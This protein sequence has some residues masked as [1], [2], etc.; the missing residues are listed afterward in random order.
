MFDISIFTQSLVESPFSSNYSLKSLQ[1][2]VV[3]CI[4]LSCFGNCFCL[5]IILIICLILF[6]VSIVIMSII[7]H[8]VFPSHV[9]VFLCYLSPNMPES[10]SSHSSVISGF[11][12]FSEFFLHSSFS[13]FPALLLIYIVM[14]SPV[15]YSSYRFLSFTNPVFTILT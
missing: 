1:R 4:S 9:S 12:E 11:L 10:V 3:I 14:N 5:F 13:W 8:L 6:M 7:M 15:L 2:F